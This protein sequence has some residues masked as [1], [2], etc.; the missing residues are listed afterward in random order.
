MKNILILMMKR[1]FRTIPLQ[2]PTSVQ[3]K[4]YKILFTNS[5]KDTQDQ[6]NPRLHLNHHTQI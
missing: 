1:G 4:T 3:H 2:T 5:Y 6:Q